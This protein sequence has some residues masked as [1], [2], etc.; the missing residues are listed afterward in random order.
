MCV[1]VVIVH[2]MRMR[3]IILLSVACLPL[4]YFSTLSHELKDFRGK[5]KLRNIK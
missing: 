5:K 2:A 4:P 3:R 1:T